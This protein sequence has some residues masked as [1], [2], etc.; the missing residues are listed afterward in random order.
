MAAAVVGILIAAAALAVCNN[1][2]GGSWRQVRRLRHTVAVMMVAA[3]G[4]GSWH[5][6]GGYGGVV[7]FGDGDWDTDVIGAAYVDGNWDG[8]DRG[9]WQQQRRRHT[10]VVVVAT[11]GF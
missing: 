10:V 1:Q 11:N 5:S 6:G 3:Y 4:D 8:G 9:I 7:A 2:P